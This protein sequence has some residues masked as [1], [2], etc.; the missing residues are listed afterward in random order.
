MAMATRPPVA[1][2]AA[3]L[4][5]LDSTWLQASRLTATTGRPQANTTAA[6]W[7]SKWMLNVA[8]GVMLPPALRAPPI[9]TIWRILDAMR[10][11]LIS[12]MARFVIGAMQAMVM[13]ASG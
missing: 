11:S 1:L 8:A 3:S 6:A 2:S 10:G 7:G 5:L 12:A 13:A 9:S 4:A